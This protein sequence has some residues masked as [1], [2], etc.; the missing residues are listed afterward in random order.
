MFFL[1]LAAALMGCMVY[2]SR[3]YSNPNK[4][5]FIFG[6]KGAGK[7]TYMLYL[8]LKHLK[9]GWNVYTNMTDVRLDGVRIMDVAELKT[10]A[11]EPHSVLFIDEAGLIWDNRN[12]KSFDA[13]YTEFFKLQRKYGCK[14]YIN[15]QAFDID[16]KLRDLTDSMVLMSCLCGCIG[17]VRPIIRKV[18]LVEASAQ[19]DSRIA[20]NLKFGSLFSF[21]FLWLPKYFKY[22]DSF[23]APERPP[24]TYRTVTSDLKVLR[25][26]SPFGALKTMEFDERE[27]DEFDD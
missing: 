27:E 24:V 8:M 20:D 1:V 26:R 23:N 11:P 3:K 22:F 18:A 9:A 15:S 2:F 16:K 4:L 10:C 17:V 12:F 5:I 6:K 14:M 7:S 19:G 25:S 21:K 13:G